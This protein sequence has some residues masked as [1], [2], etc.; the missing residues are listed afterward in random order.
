MSTTTGRVCASVEVVLGTLGAVIG[1]FAIAYVSPPSV[2]IARTS[3]GFSFQLG[4][5]Y[6][7]LFELISIDGPPAWHHPGLL[8]SQPLLNNSL[9]L[10]V[11]CVSHRCRNTC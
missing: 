11:F 5:F 1:T 10:L 7:G 9:L 4:L 2:A 3:C 6:V 8:H